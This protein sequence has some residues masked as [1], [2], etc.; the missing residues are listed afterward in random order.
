MSTINEFIKNRPYLVWYT[1]N[2][3]NLTPDSIVEAVL[4][5]GDW[6]DVQEML[7]ILGVDKTAEIFNKTSQKKRNNYRERTK[8]YFSRY[9][10]KY[11][12]A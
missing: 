1:K 5:Y 10:K 2:H 3:E 8:E 9:F 4:N 12:H 6:E 11:S 7:K